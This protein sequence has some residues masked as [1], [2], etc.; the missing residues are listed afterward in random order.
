[1][2]NLFFATLLCPFI[3]W[4]DAKAQTEFDLELGPVVTAQNDVRI[5]GE[6]ERSFH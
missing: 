2:R 6:G 5:P 3:G 1:M 4:S